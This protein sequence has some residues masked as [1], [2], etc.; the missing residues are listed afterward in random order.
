[1]N[2][3]ELFLASTSARANDSTTIFPV[4]AFALLD[5]I[6][7]NEQ[8]PQ[9]RADDAAD[10]EIITDEVSHP[11]IPLTLAHWRKS[12]AEANAV[13]NKWEL[14]KLLKRWT[15]RGGEHCQIYGDDEAQNALHLELISS[16]KEEDDNDFIM[17]WFKRTFLPFL[18]AKNRFSI[19]FLNDRNLFYIFRCAFLTNCSH[20]CLPSGLGGGTMRRKRS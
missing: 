3:F 7:G 6:L 20:F 10:S 8:W 1:M 4:E 19:V 9:T 2:D 16:Y 12:E 11:R 14:P 18:W 13:Q 15:L 5:T 17:Y